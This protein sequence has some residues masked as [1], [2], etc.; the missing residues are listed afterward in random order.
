MAAPNKAV[1]T[2]GPIAGTLI[3]LTISMSF[4][5][6]GMV[7][8]N[9]V[10][11][12]FVGKLGTAQ[13]AALGFTLPAV[14]MVQSVAL[15]LGVGASAVISRAI[16]EGGTDRVKRL[17]TDSLVL[18]VVIVIGL[19]AA[20][21]LTIKP[22]FRLLGASDDVLPLIAQYMR[23]WYLGLLFVVVPMI[24]NNAIRATGDA[25]TPALIM[26]VGA[27]TNTGLD[28]LLIFGPG[29]F[30]RLEIQ[31]AAVA[32][33]FA[34][35]VT[36]TVSLWVLGRRDKMLSRIVPRLGQVLASW[37]RVLYIGVPTTATRMVVPLAIGVITKIVS[38]YGTPAV[39]GYGVSSRIEFFAFTV[40]VALSS[41]LMP[42]VGQNWGAGRLDR[43]RAGA[44]FGEIFA[45]IWGGLLFMIL[46]VF[47]RP[48]A[49]LF[50]DNPEVIATVV[51][52]LRI[53]PF[54]YGLQGMLQVSVASLNAL[55]RPLYASALMLAQMF[56]LYIPLAFL[57]SRLFGLAGVFGALGLAYF[58]G[59][60]AG[61]GVLAAA[62]SHELR[63]AGSTG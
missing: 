27:L 3:R 16:G 17:T 5:M 34:R 28:P 57:G 38:T 11:T 43:V 15:G 59:G 33:V 36:L 42:F 51:T 14:L 58:I 25:R 12:Y 55:N 21:L 18:G 26:V 47:A 9:L 13:L 32:T 1:L 41:V 48:V 35:G 7:A 49:G 40:V 4:G 22:V 24:G 23:I 44:R 50:N 2:E 37:K 39:A 30:P 53:V 8:F 54:A 45:L 61:H 6:V 20:G 10:D 62:I 31:G 29:P 56:C 52:Y 60:F 46:A 19:V 63:K